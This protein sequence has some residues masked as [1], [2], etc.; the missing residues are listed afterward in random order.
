[1][2]NNVIIFPSNI[3]ITQKQIYL[4]IRFLLYSLSSE[5]FWCDQGLCGWS[6]ILQLGGAGVVS[7]GRWQRGSL[8]RR[9]W[10]R[11]GSLHLHSRCILSLNFF[12]EILLHTTKVVTLF[13][14]QILTCGKVAIF[15]EI[16]GK[17]TIFINICGK[18]KI[19]RWCG[20]WNGGG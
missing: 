5:G 13:V 7:A 15:I 18:V 11:G 12:L 14:Q 10:W 4:E 17:V 6:F 2:N 8:P 16:C 20:Q 9:W 3:Q 19:F 1:M